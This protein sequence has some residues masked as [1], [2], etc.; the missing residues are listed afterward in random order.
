MFSFFNTGFLKKQLSQVDLI[1]LV[2]KALILVFVF[3]LVT[4]YL[5]PIYPDEIQ[6]R[7]ALSRL[8]FDFPLKISGSPTCISNFTQP[9]PAIMYIPGIVNWILHGNLES[10]NSLRVIGIA[11]P[12]LWIS[13]LAFYSRKKVWCN[14]IDTQESSLSG[15]FTTLFGVFISIFAIGVYPFFLI[16]NRNEQLIL[17]SIVALLFI[18]VTTHRLK[19]DARLWQKIGLVV[20]YFIAVSLI[21]YGHAK[22]LFLTP[23]LVFVGWQLFSQFKSRL[24]FFILMPL[25]GWHVIQ[26]YLA[27]K[28]AFQCDDNPQIAAILK[29]FSLDPALL[30]KEPLNFLYQAFISLLF[31]GKYLLQLG[32]QSKTD[33]NY[34]PPLPLGFFATSVNIFVWLNFT[35]AFY[36]ICKLLLRHYWL[37]VFK[38]NFFTI[39]TTLLLLT[40]CLIIGGIFNIP[41]N[42][43]DAGY[44]YSVLIIVWIFFIVENSFEIPRLFAKRLYFYLACVALISQIVLIYRNLPS[45]LGGYVG[46][47]ISIVEY[48][49]NKGMSEISA[50]ALA[51]G[52]DPIH[53]KKLILDDYTYLYFRRSSQPMPI[54]YIFYDGNPVAA[55]KFISESD[56]DGL[57]TRCSS[58]GAYTPF[59]KH[60]GEV[61]CI[62]KND[63]NK[64]PLPF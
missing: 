15:R 60:A 12:L 59:A 55:Q 6:V 34:L 3:T 51:C 42:W 48:K 22:G 29:S 32:F 31:F 39:N 28:Y 33:I 30:Y 36:F 1:R 24:L 21:L 54:T 43:Y 63:L 18:S 20:M 53:S 13:V 40:L 57:I 35:L 45:F 46:P 19:K 23:F 5:L 27:W 16:L 8:P 50:A 44:F 4:C 2:S 62:P 56:S 41:K 47:S 10:L 11:I 7:I 25:L 52:I 37:D 58:I 64:L 26:Y 9:F 17:P 38:K 49:H 14:L 61:C